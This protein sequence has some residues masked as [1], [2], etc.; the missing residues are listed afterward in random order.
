[1]AILKKYNWEVTLFCLV[2]I[3]ILGFGMINPRML[4]LNGHF[5]WFDSRVMRHFIG[6]I[7]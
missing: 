6:G 3:E 1:M 5:F 7:V 2:I 4:D